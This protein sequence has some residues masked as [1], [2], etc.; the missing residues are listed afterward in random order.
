MDLSNLSSLSLSLSPSLFFSQPLGRFC[1]S[2]E[3]YRHRDCDLST[4]AI[5]SSFS[6]AIRYRACAGLFLP[7]PVSVRLFVRPLSTLARCP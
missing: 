2:G 6:A 3:V 4:S 7:K 1:P 5:E